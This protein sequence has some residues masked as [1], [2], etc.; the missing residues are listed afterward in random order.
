M[1][2]PIKVP[3]NL[4]EV[5]AAIFLVK[6]SEQANSMTR[7]LL[8]KIREEKLYEGRFMNFTEFV[9]S[10]EGLGK[11]ASWASKMCAVHEYYCLQGKVAADQLEEVE[12]EKLYLAMNIKGYT[13]EQKATRAKSWT[14]QDIKD[15]TR[16]QEHGICEHTGAYET[17]RKCLDCGKFVRIHE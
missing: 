7:E 6:V 16:E 5:D 3:A 12:N 4:N 14:R 15:E 17:F 1:S 11:S 9:E 13:P 8:W 10:P 2:N